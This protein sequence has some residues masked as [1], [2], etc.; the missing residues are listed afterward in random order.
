MY[1]DMILD[2][3]V[4]LKKLIES[5][6]ERTGQ[7]FDEACSENPEAFILAHP[8]RFNYDGEVVERAPPTTKSEW[9]AAA[10]RA[11]ARPDVGALPEAFAKALEEQLC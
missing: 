8:E 9:L 6:E 1:L 4:P 3:P 7:S 2:K 10:G 11:A 5:F